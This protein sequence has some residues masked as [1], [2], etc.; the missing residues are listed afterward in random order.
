[1]TKGEKL[2]WG[3]LRASRLNGL[4]FRRQCGIGIYI[5]DFYCPELKLAIEIDGDVHGYEVRR[6]QDEDREKSLQKLG[7]KVLR[8]TNGEVIESINGVLEQ[9]LSNHPLT[10]SLSKEGESGDRSDEL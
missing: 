6:I 1:M 8:F 10:P 2:L 4:K 5:V 7:I 3:R 9:I